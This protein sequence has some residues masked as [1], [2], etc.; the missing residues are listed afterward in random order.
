VNSTKL[1]FKIKWLYVFIVVLIIVLG[2]VGYYLYSLK[3]QTKEQNHNL[4][5]AD[6]EQVEY[7]IEEKKDSPSSAIVYIKEKDSNKQIFKFQIENIIPNHYYPYEAHKCGIYL[8][9]E[10]NYDYI[11][12]KTLPD[13]RMEVWRY[14]YNGVGEKL[15]EESDF[16]VDSTETYLVLEQSYLGQPDYAIVIKSLKSSNL[17]DTFVLKYDDLINKYSAPQGNLS[18]G[19]WRDNGR[20][21]WGNIFMGAE[22]LA[23]FRIEVGSWITEV[24]VVPKEASTVENISENGEYIT[25][26]NG[27]G[28]IA[29][30]EDAQRIYEEW[31]KEGKKVSLFIYNLFTKEKV[32]L[33]TTDNP[34]WNFNSQ[35]ISDT[36][37]QYEMPDGE[38]RIYK[39][40]E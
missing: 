21:F 10:F 12:G 2:F 36:E 37:L 15:V 20:Y 34:E 31:R 13:F 3:N 16:R 22:T 9:R 39:I 8:V 11:K 29:I 33:A 6:D 28:W 19:R 35:W 7:Q 40:E 23:F 4:C 32:K 26:N 17:K 24:F 27:P 30:D 14:T 25:Y 1:K 38:K 5:L 18:L